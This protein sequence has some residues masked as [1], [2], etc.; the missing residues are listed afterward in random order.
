MPVDTFT[1]KS[2]RP[3]EADLKERVGRSF[4]LLEKTLVSSRSGRAH[5]PST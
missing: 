4:Q 3:S 1:N 2:K 5:S